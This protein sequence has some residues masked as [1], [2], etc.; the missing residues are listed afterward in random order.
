MVGHTRRRDKNADR[1][2]VNIPLAELLIGKFVF[3]SAV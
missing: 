1:N 2:E 3:S